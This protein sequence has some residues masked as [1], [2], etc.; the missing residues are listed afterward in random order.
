M[1]INIK[2]SQIMRVSRR[3]ELLWDI[4]GN[5]K[6]NEIDHFKYLGSVLTRD[7][8]CTKEIKIKIAIQQKILLLTS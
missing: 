1:E 7:D 8:Y 4:V 6:L 2:K 5:R 3:N